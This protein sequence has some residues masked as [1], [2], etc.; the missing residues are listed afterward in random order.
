M[1]VATVRMGKAKHKQLLKDPDIQR[2][3]N[4]LARGS[5]ITA[6]ERLRRLGRFCNQAGLTPRTLVESKRTD[7]EGFEKFIMDFVDQSFARGDK[8]TQ[9]K[10]NLVTVKSWLAHF[11]LKVESRIKLPA[12]DYID[13][14][15]P[16]KEELASI[17]RNC[18][19]RARVI[20]SLTAYSALRP[21]SMGNY[22]GN[23]GLRLKDLPELRIDG[24]QVAIE[25]VPTQVRVRKTLS[26]ARHQYF[27]FLGEEG[28]KYLKEY[29]DARIR[30]GEKLEAESPI[31]GHI[32]PGKLDFMRTT[33]LSW[34]V[35]LAMKKAGFSWRPYVLRSYCATA[36]DIAESRGWLSH[37]W[38]QFFMGHK[39][40]IEARYST[41]KARLPPDMVEEMR[42][43]YKKCESLLQTSVSEGI[44]E[45]KI[46]RAFKEQLLLVA[47]FKKAE[48]EKM[49]FESMDEEQ[50]QSIIRQRLLGVMANNGSKQKVIAVGEV[51]GH[52]SQGWEF[53]ATLPGDRAILR[54]PF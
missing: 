28:C 49:D 41:N 34:E 24:D 50:F 46:K 21:G 18:D 22:L 35:K 11:G 37:P 25:K 40:D 17:L 15:V 44:D 13:E 12:I 19:S 16:S 31:V 20:A 38:R 39:G 30:A 32:R 4:N 5:I 53:V 27:T 48:V 33:K 14:V 36:F 2:W 54:I 47:G 10:N 3:F 42:G 6:E 43:A 51:E 1:S 7:S 45:E 52:L 29:L 26:K 8:P 9:V 23:D